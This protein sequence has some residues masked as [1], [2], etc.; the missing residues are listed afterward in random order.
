LGSIP[1]NCRSSEARF[2]AEAMSDRNRV[3]NGTRV[4]FGAA[5]DPVA[6]GGVGT[7]TGSAVD[8]GLPNTNFS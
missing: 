5:R 1:F 4:I 2:T 3:V 8:V 7:T 6:T